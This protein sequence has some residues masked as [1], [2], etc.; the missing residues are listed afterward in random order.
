MRRF[1]RL[2]GLDIRL[3]GLNSREDLR[4]VSFL[5]MH[6]IDTVLDVGA[7]RGQF[8]RDLI[9]A[10]YRGRVI[11]FEPLPDAHAALVREASRYTGDWRVAPRKALSDT[12]GT[13]TFHVTDRDTSSSLL[14]N[15][16][17]ARRCRCSEDR[18]GD[19]SS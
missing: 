13:A 11:S 16:S 15:G 3:N 19:R 17:D 1:G 12:N 7:N 14:N 4:F 8:A 6:C 10:G 5:E 18:S 9:A 2:F